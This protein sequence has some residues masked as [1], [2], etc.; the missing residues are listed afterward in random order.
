MH[1]YTAKDTYFFIKSCSLMSINFKEYI[2]PFVKI[3]LLSKWLQLTSVP[4]K[5][6]LLSN[7]R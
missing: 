5:E 4:I 6:L 3:L 7:K 2:S 1:I